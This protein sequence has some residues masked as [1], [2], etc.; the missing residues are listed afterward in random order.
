[1]G[2]IPIVDK[3]IRVT[4]PDYLDYFI[5]KVV[6]SRPRI[7]LLSTSSAASLRSLLGEMLIN[8]CE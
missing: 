2:S 7:S 8:G 6:S 3:P 4:V 1:M 5:V